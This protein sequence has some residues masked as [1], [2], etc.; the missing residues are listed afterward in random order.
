MRS[1]V[2]WEVLH[3][4][5][6]ASIQTYAAVCA[7]RR[8]AAEHPAL[9]PYADGESVVGSLAQPKGELDVKE[10]VLAALVRMAQGAH[11]DLGS[12]L[13]WLGLWPGLDA[14]Y[15]RNLRHVESPFDLV[16]QIGA[17]FTGELRRID[18]HHVHRIAA[19]VVRNTERT[20]VTEYKKRWEHLRWVA[21]PLGRGP[22]DA[23]AAPNAASFERPAWEGA[24]ERRS[25]HAWEERALG[26]LEA[27]V[28][29][30]AIGQER[31]WLLRWLGEV[32]G[33][34]A[35]LVAAVVVWEQ[36]QRHA[37]KAGGLSHEAARKRFRR[38]LARVRARLE[39]R[40]SQAER[41]T[42]VSVGEEGT[43]GSTTR[44][45]T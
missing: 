4:R 40:M 29:V 31:Q 33:R 7:F 3:A 43:H 32:M 23:G 20:L 30:S 21:A 9:A 24:L 41:E 27:L 1:R 2:P 28:P 16:S 13:L 44:R 14:V 45:R 5:L 6:R 25:V 12:A 26:E 34:D 38:A 17:A 35:Q 18:L 10:A 8:A 36:D 39:E 15:R 22:A 37:G 19:T 42:R 11:Q